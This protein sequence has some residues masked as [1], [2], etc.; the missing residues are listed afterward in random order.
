M[1]TSPWKREVNIAVCH[2]P[3]LLQVSHTKATGTRRQESSHHASTG[4]PRHQ[5]TRSQ[6]THLD[7][8]LGDE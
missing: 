4:L 6:E 8:C 2:L 5:L 7:F 1:G 3:M